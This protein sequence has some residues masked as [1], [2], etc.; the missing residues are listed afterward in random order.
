MGLIEKVIELVFGGDRNVVRD[1]VEVFRENAEAGAARVAMITPARMMTPVTMLNGVNIVLLVGL[2]S[3]G[4][5]HPPFRP[6]LSGLSS[7]QD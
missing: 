1:T 2:V 7:L 4:I 5:R 3:C 6:P